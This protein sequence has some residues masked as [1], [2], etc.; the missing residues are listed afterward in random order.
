V[1]KINPAT[2]YPSF[3]NF[4]FI[5]DFEGTFITGTGFCDSTGSDTTMHISNAP[6]NEME[7]QYGEVYLSGIKTQYYGV[8]C[9]KYAL[10]NTPPI[11]LEMNY[12]CNTQF[13]VG[14]VAYDASN[15]YLGQAIALTLR[16]NFGWNKV[17]VNLNNAVIGFGAAKYSIFFSMTKLGD[18]S[19][20]YLDNV[21]LIY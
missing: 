11:F 13:S 15:N 16:P 17:Y 21:K 20:F 1:L 6:A 5:Q 14:V 8:T 7:G 4:S 2:T 12:N 3:S 18:P 19:Y 10:Q 9:T